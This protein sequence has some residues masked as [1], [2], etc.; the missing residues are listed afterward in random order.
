M[1]VEGVGNNE[2]GEKQVGESQV[3]WTIVV[4]FFLRGLLSLLG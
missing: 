4:H 1:V 3:T 2:E